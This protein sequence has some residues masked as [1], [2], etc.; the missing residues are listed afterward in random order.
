MNSL[1][2]IK[3]AITVGN[4]VILVGSY[5]LGSYFYKNA[6]ILKKE[7]Q[8]LKNGGTSAYENLV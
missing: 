1:T 6:K 5:A 2:W 7:S 8:R 3:V 4:V